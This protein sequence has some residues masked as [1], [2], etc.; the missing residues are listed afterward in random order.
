MNRRRFAL[1]IG[2]GIGA[3]ALALTRRLRERDR[4]VSA[5]SLAEALRDQ[6]ATLE[7]KVERLLPHRS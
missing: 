5:D 2:V 3:L 1:I 6:L 4:E 7:S